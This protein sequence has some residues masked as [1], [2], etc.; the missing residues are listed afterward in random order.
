M[1]Y[2]FPDVRPGDLLLWRILFFNPCS[3]L[4]HSHH[5]AGL[6]FHACLHLLLH[7]MSFLALS[8]DP[9][10]LPQPWLSYLQSCFCTPLPACTH[11]DASLLLS[12]FILLQVQSFLSSSRC[13]FVP[14]RAVLHKLRVWETRAWQA[15]SVLVFIILNDNT[16]CYFQ[17]SLDSIQE[18]LI[19]NIWENLGTPTM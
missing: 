5:P 1:E 13:C 8:V 15:G 11:Q 3:W 10:S 6:F 7:K 16:Q 2:C 17:H 19:T 9:G 4:S 18:F 14:Y 12:P